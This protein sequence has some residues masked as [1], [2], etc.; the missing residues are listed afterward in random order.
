M[1]VIHLYEKHWG[2]IEKPFEN[3]PDPR[4]LYKSPSILEVYA[5]LLY[6]LKSNRGAAML[7]GESGCGKTLMARTLIQ[8]LNPERMEVALITNPGRKPDELLR[9]VLYQIGENDLPE[10]HTQTVHRLNEILYENFSLGKET[11]VV[12]DEGQLLEETEVF[13]EI[14]LMLNFQLNDAFLLTLLLV[15]QPLLAER[16]RDL[17]QLDERLSARS[18]LKPLEKEEVGAYISHRM[19]MAGCTDPVFSPGAIELISQYSGGI[20][21]RLNH[22]CD[23]CLII[24][25]SRTATAIDEALVHSLILNEEE[26]HV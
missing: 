7:T 13:E 25:Y 17:P 9:E 15:G 11:I 12:I 16:V 14:R 22:I 18:I 2:L 5:K 19:D 23:T 21:R 3:T 6:A 24:G 4:F 8:E 26:S 20:P 1:E 10:D